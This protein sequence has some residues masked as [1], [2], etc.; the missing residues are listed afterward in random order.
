MVRRRFGLWRNDFR[1]AL[2]IS[3]TVHVVFLIF[4]FST[5]KAKPLLL[6]NKRPMMVTLITPPS[7]SPPEVRVVAPP[8][9]PKVESS[10]RERLLDQLRR[11]RDQ[12]ARVDPTPT[13]TRKPAPR[14]TPAPSPRP[15]TVPTQ[16][17]QERETPADAPQVTPDPNMNNLDIPIQ[18]GDASFRYSHFLQA[19]A[20]RLSA[21]WNPPPLE[22]GLQE[23]IA[24]CQFRVYRDGTISDVRIVTSSGQKALDDSVK[25]AVMR[26]S[27]FMQ[28]PPEYRS[29]YIE[30]RA[31][32]RARPS[33]E[34]I[35]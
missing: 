23:A 28:L 4:I 2:T 6:P 3:A 20:G 5:A 7:E 32:F 15:T 8:E 26:S 25:L 12:V 31:P 27:P 16:R 34:R 9:P 11:A 24:V 17:P 29:D 10:L 22:G 1:V 35:P 13:P 14:N 30:V 19:L 18:V 33:M 21:N